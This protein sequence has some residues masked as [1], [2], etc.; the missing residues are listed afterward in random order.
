MSIQKEIAE[1]FNVCIAN[2]RLGYPM[3]FE[4]TDINLSKSIVFTKGA[5]QVGEKD[6]GHLIFKNYFNQSPLKE[7]HHFTKLSSFQSILKTGSIFMFAVHKRFMAPE[8]K[9]FYKDHGM[10]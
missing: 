9:P 3:T 10:D 7:F 5:I 4:A 1:A 8:F 2:E 6:L